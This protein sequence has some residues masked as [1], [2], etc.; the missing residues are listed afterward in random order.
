MS[1]AI[2]RQDKAMMA[3]APGVGPKLAARLVLELKDKS[4][5]PGPADFGGAIGGADPGSKLPKAAEDAVLALV[6]LGYARPQAATAVAKGFAALGA[7]AATA[8]LIRMGLKELA[9]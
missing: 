4:P 7:D 3:R 9:Q 8:A 6:G 2:S 5:M 1:A